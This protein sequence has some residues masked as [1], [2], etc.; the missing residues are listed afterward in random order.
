MLT[1][2]PEK[3]FEVIRQSDCGWNV[4]KGWVK[5]GERVCFEKPP[6]FE[7][8]GIRGAKGLRVRWWDK[9]VLV[10]GR[11][12]P[13]RMNRVDFK[14]EPIVEVDEVEVLRGLKGSVGW[15]LADATV[16]LLVRRS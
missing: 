13:K 1:T 16:R 8:R 12:L 7:E 4:E 11:I 2:V 9:R 15:P 3:I 10:S 6:A 5:E 14:L